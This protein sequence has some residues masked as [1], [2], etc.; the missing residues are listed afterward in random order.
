MLIVLGDSPVTGFK[1]NKVIWFDLINDRFQYRNASKR[2]RRIYKQWRLWSDCSLQSD[3]SLHCLLRVRPN[4]Y[5]LTV[6]SGQLKSFGLYS[7][8]CIMTPTCL[9]KALLMKR[10]YLTRIPRNAVSRLP[11]LF[12]KIEVNLWT[13]CSSLYHS[14]ETTAKLNANVTKLVKRQYQWWNW[15]LLL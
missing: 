9:V 11:A 13:W 10:F 8:K 4:T 15:A 5:N 1:T 6:N 3:Q 2:C 12:H 14:W 7:S